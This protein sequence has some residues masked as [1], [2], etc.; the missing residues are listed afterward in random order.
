MRSVEIA[1]VAALLA[2]VTACATAINGKQDTVLFTSN[3]QGAKVSA[4]DVKRKKP[5]QTCITP[6]EMELDRKWPHAVVFE[7]AD[8]ETQKLA[9][10]PKMTAEGF[11]SGLGNVLTF[12]IGEAV[13]GPNAAYNDL[14][15]N[16]L[17]AD[18][19]ALEVPEGS[20]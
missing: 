12:G 3:P 18:L 14:L 16:P 10:T 17:H 15:P 7:L 11:A 4:R 1:A 19:Q 8:Y 13:D 2:S 6:C 5:V 9:L 20:E